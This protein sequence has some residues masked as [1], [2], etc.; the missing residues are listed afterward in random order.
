MMQLTKI[1]RRA[2]IISSI[3]WLLS[4]IIQV[5]RLFFE[6]ENVS[7]WFLAT[8]FLFFIFLFVVW[9]LVLGTYEKIKCGDENYK[10]G[11]YIFKVYIII[12]LGMLI[13]LWPGTWA[14]DDLYTLCCI[15][16]YQGWHPWQHVLTGAY[17]SVLLQILPFPGGIILLQNIIISV[18]ISFSIAKIENIFGIRKMQNIFWDTLVKIL[19]FLLPPVL[20]YQFSGYRIGLYVYIEFTMLVMLI[21]ALK[22]KKEWS[23]SYLILFSLLSIVVATWRSESFFYVPSICLLIL[24][25]KKEI[26]PN[27]KKA[28]CVLTIIIGFI[29]ISKFQNWAIGDS[30]YQVMSLL[31]PCVDVVRVADRIDDAELLEDINKVAKLELIYDN[32]T[33][34][35]AALYYENVVQAGYSDNDYRDFLLAIVKLTL[36]YPR[37]VL[38]ERWNLFI[39]GT[40]ITG[41]SSTNVGQ[42]ATMFDDNSGNKAAYLVLD[43]DW[44]ANMPISKDIRKNVILFL[45]MIR[46]D[47]SEIIVPHRIIWNTVIPLIILI[48]EWIGLLIRRKWYL[49]GICTAILIKVPIVILTEPSLSIMYQLSFYFL[50][51]VCLVYHILIFWSGRNKGKG[52]EN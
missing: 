33:H 38:E 10:R 24:C 19:P 7:R 52:K 18:C 30:N 11:L 29:G 14:W 49:W 26:I 37:V 13:I 16:Q 8:K 46:D 5:D 50:G 12:M 36:K 51:Y 34:S 22:D 15:S 44:I 20:M 28:I 39:A 47:G 41:M 40:G 25:A 43:K 17:Q 42:A 35:G 27:K 48:I 2:I 45:G 4:S 32:P 31:N 9:N 23:Y 6:Y 1:N 21:G 3:Q